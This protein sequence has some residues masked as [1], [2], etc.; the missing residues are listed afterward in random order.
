MSAAIIC[1]NVSYGIP[2]LCRLIWVRNDMPKGPFDLGKFGLPLNFISVL[3]ITFFS[4]ILCIPPFSPITPEN[5]NWSP[6]MIGGVMAFSLFFWLISGRY[7][8]KGTNVNTAAEQ[9]QE[10]T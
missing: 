3:W 4:V 2:F 5:F 6:V 8:Y 9:V 7:N 10:S 1:M